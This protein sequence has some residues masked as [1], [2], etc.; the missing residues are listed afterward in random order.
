MSEINVQVIQELK[1][2]ILQSRYQAA[3]LVNKELV[4][5]YFS[6]GEKISLNTKSAAWGSKILEQVS[7]ELQK[8]LPGLKGFSASNLQRM[9][10]VFDFWNE[11]LT[12]QP[13][14]SGKLEKE[15]EKEE[16][17]IY[18]TVSGKLQSVENNGFI[19]SLHRNEIDEIFFTISFSHHYLIAS[20]SKKMELKYQFKETKPNAETLK[21]LLD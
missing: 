14:V 1:S 16:N 5:L 4:S 15:Q 20:K 11:N 13:T 3:R 21:K 9:M 18:P 8:E 19:D 12:I 10:L 2:A 7:T 17:S 6:I